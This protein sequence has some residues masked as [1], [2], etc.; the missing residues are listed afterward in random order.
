[1]R[2][3]L[4][5]VVASAFQAKIPA[6]KS[7]TA[8]VIPIAN[9]R[10]STPVCHE[11]ES[12]PTN[13]RSSQAYPSKIRYLALPSDETR[14]S[15]SHIVSPN[16]ILRMSRTRF[17]CARKSRRRDHRGEIPGSAPGGVHA[18]ASTALLDRAYGRP[19]SF[20]T[21]D[22]TTFKRAIDMTDDELA[23]IVGGAKLTVV[24]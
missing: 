23:A 18:K 12:R 11:I 4:V 22:P 5:S 19:A 6:S 14:I 2:G 16:G 15:A 9:V 20:S 10:I 13:C 7:A 3:C 24:K 8:P 1:M 21:T 17:I